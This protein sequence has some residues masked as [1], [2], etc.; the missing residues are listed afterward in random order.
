MRGTFEIGR[1][2]CKDVHMDWDDLRYVLAIQRQR[3]LT[4]AAASLGVTRTTVGRRLK[5]LEERLEARLFDRTQDGFVLTS[6]GDDIVET[7]QRVEMEILAAEGRILGRDAALSGRLRVSTVDFVF[8]H[9]HDVFSTF[10]KRYPG[11]E[12]TVRVTNEV[13]SLL[14]READVALRIGN[15][16]AEHLSGRRIGRMQ[17]EVYAARTLVERLGPGARLEDYPWIYPDERSDGRWLDRWLAKNAPGARVTMRSD[18]YSVIRKAVS[19]GMGVYFLTCFDGDAD[20]GLMR[21]GARL[22]EE[23]RDLWVL[24]LPDL[25]HNSR[26]RAFM[27]HVYDAFQARRDELEGTMPPQLE[28]A[29]VRA[30]GG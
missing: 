30:S 9:F 19:A 17:I 24:S 15:T 14:R 16:P 2:A 29:A 20:P 13:V 11:V 7:A 12:L 23:A 4:D 25:R 18:D 28:G 5:E 3:T 8:E 1:E 26:I 27:D 10:M 21:L 6:A 22:V